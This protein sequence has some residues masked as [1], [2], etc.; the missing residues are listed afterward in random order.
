[1]ADDHGFSQ[2]WKE[3]ERERS[4]HFKSSFSEMWS[5]LKNS[6]RRVPTRAKSA[7]GSYAQSD[8]LAKAA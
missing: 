7:D 6:L 8:T 1:M 4:A 2:V 5:S 3:A